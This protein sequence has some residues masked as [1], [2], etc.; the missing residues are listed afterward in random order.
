MT[1]YLCFFQVTHARQYKLSVVPSGAFGQVMAR[2]SEW[3]DVSMV[4]IWRFGF[5]LRDAHDV[6]MLTV[7]NGCDIF[8]RICKASGLKSTPNQ[9]VLA[10]S[11]RV[12]DSQA[13]HGVGTL[14]RRVDEELQQIFRFLYRRLNTMPVEMF[15][16]CPHCIGDGLAPSEGNWIK[17]SD[18]VKQVLSAQP[19]FKCGE[20]DVVR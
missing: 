10:V 14:L 15:V 6:A 9:S 16:L 20:D 19:T 17:H 2:V 4:E 5:V 18:V 8:L 12:Q 1:Y 13:L 11:P 7:E 3:K